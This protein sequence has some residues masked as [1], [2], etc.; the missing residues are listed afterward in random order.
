MSLKT[1]VEAYIG[2]QSASLT[3]ALNNSL[4]LLAPIYPGL[5]KYAKAY[6]IAE[7]T[8]ANGV[9]FYAMY[10]NRAANEVDYGKLEAFANANS[11]YYIRP[12]GTVGVYSY[13]D[14]V[15]VFLPNTE[16]DWKAYAYKY[17]ALT[18][19][20]NTF[21]PIEL[22]QPVVLHTA[23]QVL[24][25]SMNDKLNAISFTNIT[26]PVSGT[27]PTFTLTENIVPAAP[28]F[29]APALSYT[30]IPETI[31]T[32][33]T[34]GNLPTVPAFVPS[35][36]NI[37]TIPGWDE[38]ISSLPASFNVTG[39]TAP[40]FSTATVASSS[41]SSALNDLSSSLTT[42]YTELNTVLDTEEDIEL[43][44]AKI[45]EI[46]VRITQWFQQAQ[47]T[48]DKEKSNAS[49][50]IEVS[51]ANAEL[52]QQKNIEQYQAGI[53]RYETL[54]A[55]YKADVDKLITSYQTTLQYYQG[56]NNFQIAKYQAEN[57]ARWYDVQVDLEGYKAEINKIIEQAQLSQRTLEAN[58]QIEADREKTNAIQKFQKSLSQYQ[59]ELEKYRTDWEAYTKQVEAAYRN[60]SLKVEIYKA[61]L[62][63]AVQQSLTDMQVYKAK[64]EAEVSKAAVE[65][66]KFADKSGY[67]NLLTSL[68]TEFFFLLQSIGVMNAVPANDR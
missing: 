23:I 19:N 16:A 38:L 51:K 64:I 14:N 48:L 60:N 13:N 47:V 44:K 39:L 9:L 50:S 27:L 29:T 35:S 56:V 33:V 18:E 10:K 1:R 20:D 17:P 41:I 52:T 8:P 58:A 31:I 65:L 32:Q 59:L 57:Q 30:D 34:I 37:V 3:E 2:V 5:A 12:N 49:M 46:G 21:N 25:K 67:M 63:K 54:L 26:A 40:S 61:Q 66:Q 6:T 36:A 43:A 62:E 28:T 4:K 68:K 42:A 15:I 7:I 45:E 11:L 24:I 53:R 55:A 22:I